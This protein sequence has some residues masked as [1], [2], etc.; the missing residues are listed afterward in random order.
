MPVPGGEV[1]TALAAALPTG[2]RVSFSSVFTG[3]LAT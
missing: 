2:L 3:A 1:V